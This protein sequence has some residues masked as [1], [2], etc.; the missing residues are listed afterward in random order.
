MQQQPWQPREI[1]RAGAVARLNARVE[2]V[3]N[4]VPAAV[5]T[6]AAG[7]GGGGGDVLKSLQRRVQGVSV[8]EREIAQLRSRSTIRSDRCASD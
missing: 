4:G 6:H 5:A 7:S 2:A 8:W 3:R 1:D